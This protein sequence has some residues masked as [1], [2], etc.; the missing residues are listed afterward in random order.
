MWICHTDNWT[1]SS[2][3]RWVCLGMMEEKYIL[4]CIEG[5]VEGEIITFIMDN[6]Y[7]QLTLGMRLK[8]SKSTLTSSTHIYL[9]SQS[10]VLE[11]VVLFSKYNQQCMR[12]GWNYLL[13]NLLYWIFINDFHS[14]CAASCVSIFLK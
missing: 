8:V 11:H 10:H 5:N 7:T 3:N 12:I 14:K 9:L 2:M 1:N 4:Y 13:L 6:V